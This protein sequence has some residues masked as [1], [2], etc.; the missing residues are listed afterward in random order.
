MK[1]S[2][3]LIPV[4]VV[5][6]LGLIGLFPQLKKERI[7]FIINESMLQEGISG[8]DDDGWFI[9]KTKLFVKPKPT[10]DSLKV[11]LQYNQLLAKY[12]Q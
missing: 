4:M 6:L 10:R 3:E 1:D 5:L 9:I 7:N 11:T 8:G 12:K 2:K